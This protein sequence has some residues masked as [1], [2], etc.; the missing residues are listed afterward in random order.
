MSKKKKE[1]DVKEVLQN[2]IIANVK[3]L[4]EYAKAQQKIQH[5]LG[6]IQADMTAMQG[7]NSQLITALATIRGVEPSVVTQEIEDILNPDPQEQEPPVNEEIKEQ[8]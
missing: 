7:A 4:T 8:Q 6:E 1:P 2:Q 5:K 3:N